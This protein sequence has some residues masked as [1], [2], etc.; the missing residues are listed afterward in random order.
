MVAAYMRVLLLV[1]LLLVA[2]PPD[3]DGIMKPQA[4]PSRTNAASS[5]RTGDQGQRTPGIGLSWCCCS[6]WV[7]CR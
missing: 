7:A 3:G 2:A 1:L 4:P 6:G 5:G